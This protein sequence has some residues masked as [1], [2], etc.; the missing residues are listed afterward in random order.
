MG[1]R[2][3]PGASIP[4][5]PPLPEPYVERP[6]LSETLDAA[7]AA[8]DGTTG[9]R[10]V[11]VSAGPGWGKGTAVAAWAGRRDACWV[12]VEDTDTAVRG[13]AHH[14]VRALR[15][16]RPDLPGELL[17]AHPPTQGGADR[18]SVAAVVDA[19]CGLLADRLH[20]ADEIVL[21]VDGVHELPATGAAARLLAGLGERAPAGFR[22]VLI[23]AGEDR[24]AALGPARL[25]F[26]VAEVGA[27]LR[28][29]TGTADAAAE[30]HA[31][32]G[33]WPAAV[34]LAAHALQ[35]HALQAGALQAGALRA[36]AL[37]A[38]ALRA[39]AGSGEAAVGVLGELAARVL[40]AEPEPARRVLAGIA[41]LGPVDVPLW[42]AV[43]LD[44]DQAASPLPALARH[45]LLRPSGPDHRAW[46]VLEPV[47]G[48]L[49]DL[50]PDPATVREL[51]GHAAAYHAGRAE[52]RP[53]LRY[54]VAAG[55]RA[56]AT[57]ILV[58]HGD[59]M[60]AE[61]AVATVLA[62]AEALD[63]AADRDP[64]LQA[65]L[66]HARELAGDVLGA[67]AQLR[68][69]V[70]A[71]P[72]A[73]ALALR[74][75][76]LHYLAGQPTAA[77]ATFE[78]AELGDGT[79]D[80][81]RLLSTAPIWLRAVGDDE[82][83]RA[84]AQRAAATAERLGDPASMARSH[85]SLALL[86]AHGGDRATHETHHRRGLRMAELAG[87]RMLH[88]GM[89]INHASYLA[90]EGPPAAALAAADS[91]LRLGQAMGVVGYEPLCYS[92]RAR[93][94]ARLGRFAE[95]LAD[96]DT[97]LRLWQDLGPSFDVAFGLTVRGDVHRRRGEPGQ[98]QAALAE[99]L[100]YAEAAGMRPVEALA[101]GTLARAM[102]ADDLPAAHDLAE[103][104]VSVA[105]GTGTVPALLA[106]GWIALLAGDRGGAEA[107]AA[108]ARSVA[109]ARRDGAGLAEALELA[110]LA[111]PDPAAA[112]GLLVEA[113]EL[114]AE[115]GD[116]VGEARV[117]L[118]AARLSGPAGQAAAQTALTTLHRLGVRADSGVAGALAVPAGRPPIT[119]RTL[120][121]F[122]VTRDG[123]PVPSAQWRSKKARDLFK[124]LVT[125]RG[126]PAS[127]ERLMDLLWPDDP[128]ER[129]TNRLSVLLSTL[130]TVLDPGRALPEPGPLRTDSRTVALELAHVTV[131]VE[132]FLDLAAAALAADR[133]DAP[134]ATDLLAAAEDTHTG[135]FLPE[136]P[137]EEWAGP[138]RDAARTAHISV[139][140]ALLRRS[141]DPDR[142]EHHLLQ[143]LDHDPYDEQAHRQL[144]ETLRATGRHGEAQRRYD[145]YAARMREIGVTPDQ[146]I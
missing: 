105:S 108:R 39:M 84:I 126:R 66:G 143:L 1:A 68:A 48:L 123:V 40:A 7:V 88:L 55:D 76:Q 46:D 59:P 14:I 82:G 13:L 73:P 6:R 72:L 110:V 94:N 130:R 21:V 4:G 47:R 18:I 131:D 56:G 45:G 51:R 136:D 53:A 145:T 113:G 25:A 31:A 35:A 9:S 128:P 142:R 49:G 41:A 138:L 106:R 141:A 133:R 129:A 93:A 122:Q 52:Y 109:G 27:F 118:L 116:P 121:A 81:V 19:L 111:G 42:A 119:V 117:S 74:L 10:P 91:A 43:A 92:I 71:G 89:Q 54:L 75:G 90:E 85:L 33:G 62:A 95:A 38:G 8:P 20:D 64:H 34:R 127:R 70:P 69:A 26:T 23:T 146:P 78:R 115:L 120:G 3:Y 144:V 132:T 139:V 107:D 22:L 83:A 114:W 50:A 60:L 16:L 11:V 24:A 102:A 112:A 101:L 15:R 5:A 100:R 96:V 58:K 135:E 87:E 61:G 57:E 17:I 104:A 103:R 67:L 97:S 99:A 29:T 37:R 98:A 140:R 124:I 125:N 134:G 28:A 36:G 79:A 65:V 80:D 137:D 32:T 63:L 77:V 44:H 12:T 86:A 30:V 2:S